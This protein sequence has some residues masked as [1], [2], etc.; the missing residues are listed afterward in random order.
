MIFLFIPT[1]LTWGD[2]NVENGE[3]PLYVEVLS[4]SRDKIIELLSDHDIQTRTMYPDLD[5][6]S[7]FKTHNKFPNSRKFGKFGFVLPCGPD[8]P[9]E[10]VYK[11]IE[12]LK[13][14][15]D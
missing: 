12:V 3:L 4:S 10:N 14:Y 15:K 6:A 11:T 9:I 13:K 8:Q 7:Y 2:I 5:K 1:G